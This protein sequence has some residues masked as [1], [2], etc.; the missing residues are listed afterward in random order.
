MPMLKEG[1]FDWKFD[2]N[3]KLIVKVKGLTAKERSDLNGATPD[4]V[5]VQ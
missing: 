4:T 5:E 2:K 1:V 3:R